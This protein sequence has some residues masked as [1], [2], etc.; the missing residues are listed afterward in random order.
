MCCIL[1]LD[2]NLKIRSFIY[3]YFNYLCP[4]DAFIPENLNIKTELYKYIC[5]VCETF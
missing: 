3:A 4:L 5:I 1:N 2:D